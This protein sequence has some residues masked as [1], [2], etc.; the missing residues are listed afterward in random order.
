MRGIEPYKEIIMI[1]KTNKEM[2]N[3]KDLFYSTLFVFITLPWVYMCGTYVIDCIE[4]ESID[5]VLQ[6]TY[7][8][9]TSM[10]IV[11]LYINA[12]RSKN[13]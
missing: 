4:L 7:A 6:F 8:I 13:A 12:L 2:R 5:N 11:H 3:V 10:Y 1:K 9:I